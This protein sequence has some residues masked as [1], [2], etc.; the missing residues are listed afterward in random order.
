LPIRCSY[1]QPQFCSF[2]SGLAAHL[3]QGG[4]VTLPSDGTYTILVHATLLSATG[5]YVLELTCACVNGIDDDGDGLIDLADPGCVSPS[6]RSEFNPPAELWQCALG[7]E[8]LAV[9]PL[10]YVAR[11]RLASKKPT[12]DPPRP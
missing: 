1:R 12:G 6:D 4:K 7:P 3:T 10:V 11:R 2:V 9:V 8:L 5:R